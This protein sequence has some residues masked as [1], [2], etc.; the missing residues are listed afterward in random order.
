[1]Q[2]TT[3][4]AGDQLVHI[5]KRGRQTFAD[6]F[7]VAAETKQAFVRDKKVFFNWL[8]TKGNKGKQEDILEDTLVNLGETAKDHCGA[9]KIRLSKKSMSDT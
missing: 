4:R 8:V 1:M 2:V 5:F 7:M 3:G 6:S 9:Y